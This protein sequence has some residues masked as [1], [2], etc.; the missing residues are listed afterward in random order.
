MTSYPSYT[1]GHQRPVSLAKESEVGTVSTTPDILTCTS[2]GEDSPDGLASCPKCGIDFDEEKGKNMSKATAEVVDINNKSGV[3]AEARDKA[4]RELRELENKIDIA[5]TSHV[6]ADWEIGQ[7]LSKIY[8]GDLWRASAQL[9][10]EEAYK[11]F[12]DYTQRRFEFGKDTG[13]AYVAIADTFSRKEAEELTITQLW[14]LARVPDEKDRARLIKQVKDGKIETT[15]ELAAAVKA[16]RAAQ[17]LKT[18]RAGMEGVISVNARLKAGDVVAEGEWKESRS[19]G[20]YQFTFELG[21]AVFMVSRPK[22]GGT[23][24]VKVLRPS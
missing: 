14:H 7:H 13:R 11:S 16:K 18:E 17:G 22:R 6:V 9:G 8:K 12:A 2:C 5:R 21:G 4:L 19:R 3:S 20:S 23:F 24:E 10:E 1:A 15:R